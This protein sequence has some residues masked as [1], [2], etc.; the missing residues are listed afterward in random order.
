MEKAEFRI[1]MF[2]ES[3][4]VECQCL[5]NRK[6]RILTFGKSQNLEFQFLILVAR[7]YGATNREALLKNTCSLLFKALG[8]VVQS[9]VKITQG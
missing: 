9:W 3:L 7:Q 1:S 6:F 5:D 8:R 2:A 4:H